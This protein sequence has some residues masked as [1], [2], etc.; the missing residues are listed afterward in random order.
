MT[1][2]GSVT[3]SDRVRAHVALTKPRI[4]EL[5]LA[6]AVPT[7]F[8]AAG[9]LPPLGPTI[10]V[11]VGGTLA[12]GSANTFNS[13]YDRDI[14]AV[15]RRTFHRP[16]AMGIVGVRAGLVQGVVLAI[17]SAAILLWLANPLSALLSLVAIAFYAVGYT[18]LL[19][20]RTPQNIVW[21][22]AAGCM[23][24]LIAWAA[25]TGSLTWTPVVLFLIIFFWTPPHYWPLAMKY[26]EDYAAAG[27]P[28]L[29]V[30]RSEAVVA[31]SIVRYAWVMV[32]TSLVLVPV[33]PMGWVYGVGAALLGAAFLAQAYVLR[34]RVAQSAP[35]VMATAMRLFH[36]SITYLALLFL[37][38]AIDPFV[39]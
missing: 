32:A 7:T 10:G 33:A 36:G 18:M 31:S 29:P 30:V 14:D 26:R 17:A 20:R 12:A 38:V 25:V 23:P 22:G 34:R 11:L 13:V 4:V 1:A 19:K 15:M 3:A 5:L 28:M 2:E 27:I 35:D 24:V 16:A 9:G 21:G 39:F 6:T 8:L 37:L